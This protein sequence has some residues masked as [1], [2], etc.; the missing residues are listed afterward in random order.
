[1]PRVPIPDQ[2]AQAMKPPTPVQLVIQ[3]RERL[4]DAERALGGG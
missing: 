4:L 3:L 2:T 1:M